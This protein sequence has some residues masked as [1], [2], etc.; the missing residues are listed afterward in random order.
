MIQNVHMKVRIWEP[1][2]HTYH[3]QKR[4]LCSLLNKRLEIICSLLPQRYFSHLLFDL[5]VYFDCKIS[6]FQLPTLDKL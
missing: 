5:L 1:P 3:M 2:P 6:G 4:Q